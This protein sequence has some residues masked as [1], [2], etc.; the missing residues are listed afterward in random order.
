MPRS[1]LCGALAVVTTLLTAATYAQPVTIAL[2][3]ADRDLTATTVGVRGDTA[4][5]SWDASIFLTDPDGDGVYTAAVAFPEGTKRVA[6]KGVLEP[7]TGEA[8]WEPGS[9][10]LLLPGQMTEDRRA[11][12]AAQTGLPVVTITPGQLAEDLAVLRDGMTTL[13]PGLRLHNTD[14]DLAAAANRLAASARDLAATYG[15]AIPVTEAYLPIAQAVAAIR[16]GHTQ[17]SM[18]NQSSYTEAVLYDRADRVPFTFRLVADDARARMLVT[19]DATAER[20]LPAGTEI[21]TLDGRPVADVI[22]ALMPYASADGSNDA[23]RIDLLQ[24]QDLLAPAERFD[25]VYSQHF[26]PEGDL[27]L[28]VRMPGFAETD[29]EQALTIARMT[30]DARRDTLWARD[31]DLPRSRDDLL[32]YEFLDDGTAYLRIGSFSTF[33]MTL[34]YEAW[35]TGAF[36][37]F[38][39]RGTERLI[40]D[41]RGNGGGMD[42]AAALLFAHLISAPVEVPQWRGHTAYQ[43]IP[44]ALRPHLRS[45]SNDFYDLGESV[46]PQADGTFALPPRPSVT[47]SPAPDA[48]SGKVAVLIDAGPSSATFYLANTIQQTGAAP[49]VG[50]TTGGSLKGL[51]GGQMV[52]LTLPHTGFA[53]DV[54]LYGSRPLMPGPDRGVVPDVVVAPDVAA[55]AAGRDPELE[56]ALALLAEGRKGEE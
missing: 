42:D 13:H 20:V 51:N 5:L 11:F 18:Y 7:E 19:G 32:R 24:V 21:L 9:N 44:E 40:I 23:K 36:Q 6:Y 45:W 54:P 25:V 34:D 3:L 35:L 39:E 52:F 10:R 12:G 41:L 17:V 46:T 33:N 31:P 15:D 50:Q 4:P 49:L 1:L 28:T 48:F 29:T 2:D 38:R 56:A 37:A 55:L 30:A 53:V 22:T 26:A 8:E 16:D 47:V 14:A 27:A 43:T